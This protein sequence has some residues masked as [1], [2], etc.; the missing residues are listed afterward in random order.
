MGEQVK[1]LS[2][3]QV[4][5]VFDGTSYNNL[6]ASSA[7]VT[8]LPQAL[9]NEIKGARAT[10]WLWRRAAAAR[11]ARAAAAA[12]AAPRGGQQRACC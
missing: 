11:A 10:A 6:E 4:A 1:N 3:R 5:D 2:R 8:K 7:N 9:Q 12:A